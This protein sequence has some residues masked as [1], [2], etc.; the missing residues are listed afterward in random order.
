[1][2]Y[3]E[4]TE[5]FSRMEHLECAFYYN[6]MLQERDNL[7]PF[8]KRLALFYDDDKIK[9]DCEAILDKFSKLINEYDDKFQIK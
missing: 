2:T 8:F 5:I 4:M 3:E 1:M 9:K 7:R 6:D